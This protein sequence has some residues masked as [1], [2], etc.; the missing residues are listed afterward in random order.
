M[1]RFRDW[2]A[3]LTVGFGLLAGAFLSGCQPKPPINVLLIVAD[4]MGWG[5]LSL[6]GNPNVRTPH[7]D[8]LAHSGIEFTDFYVSAICSP[9]RAELF[10]G[11]HALGLGVT[12]PEA[13]G[14]RLDTSAVV[15]PEVLAK[16]GYRS[17]LFGKWHNGQQ[18]P[19]HPLSRGFEKF[20]GYTE[21]HWASYFD[22]PMLE[23]GEV[24]LRG[25]GYLPDQLTDKAIAWMASGDTRPSF[26]VLSLPTPHSP[27]QVPDRWFDAVAK[28]Q[29]DSLGNGQGEE[30]PVFTQAA[31]AMVE[32][33]DWN[34]GRLL[35]ALDSLGLRQN[36][37]VVFMSDNG[38][39]NWRWNAGM[40]GRKASVDEGGV[41]SPL[42]VSLPGR[43]D[44]GQTDASPLSVRDLFPTLCDFLG[45]AQDGKALDGRSFAERLTDPDATIADVP[46]VRAWREKT[47][48]RLG[49]Y[50]LDDEGHLYDLI[51]DRGQQVDIRED[52]T[53]TADSLEQTRADFRFA[54]GERNAGEPRPFLVGHRSQRSTH[55]SAGEA[56]VTRGV[57]PSNRYPN[58]RYLTG[59]RDT[60]AAVRW[61]V[62][63][64][65]SGKYAVTIW[66]A[67]DSTEANVEVQFRQEGSGGATAWTQVPVN[68]QPLLG[69]SQD[70]VIRDEGYYKDW[71]PTDV[72]RLD[73]LEGPD[74]LALRCVVRGA[75]GVAVAAA[76][77]GVELRSI[78]VRY[79]Q[80]N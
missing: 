70:R 14:E 35:R 9:T 72:G 73:L 22:A 4:D 59:W 57:S 47:S 69:A 54:I 34:V 2:F 77:K 64:L 37:L 55:L 17:G 38:P 43:I 53:S 78:E 36:T 32:N 11:R 62:H 56:T 51:S 25:S 30:D 66:Y 3:G 28:R 40:R 39:N 76:K 29:L 8:S 68:A 31:L 27:M 26:T 10:T 12:G 19:N 1:I 80:A 61:P 71:L 6:H 63:V 16:A 33:I 23:D 60:S 20:F 50:L 5:D 52:F 21:G 42:F 67:L 74:T 41:R 7:L 65:R 79:A 48:V 13:G 44:A 75:N 46:I 24:Y 49:R 18:P 15:L 45:I 58:S